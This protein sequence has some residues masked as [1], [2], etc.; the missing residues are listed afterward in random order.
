MLRRHEAIWSPAI[1]RHMN[2]ISYGHYGTPLI[3]FPSGL[4]NYF[5]WENFGMIDCVGHLIDAGKLKIYCTESND[6][7]TW[8]GDGDIRHRSWRYRCFE[9]YVLNNLVPTIRFDCKS[10]DI[11]IGLTGVSFGAYHAANFALKHPETFNY[12]LCMSGKYDL[13]SM[14]D[15][16]YCDDCYF[17]DPMA[18]LYNIWGEP[19]DRIRHNTH[20][21]MTVG[22][23]AHENNCIPQTH[24]LA[25][26]LHDKGIS[27]ECDTWGHDAEHHWHWWR[28]QL[29]HHLGRA[30]G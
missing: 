29:A 24:K 14:L 5:D 27:H 7:E 17:N 22:Q 23:G 13:G 15:G 8:I 26:L 10:P 30:L 4:G 20:I 18:Y 11:R 9:D 28:K 16:E 1:G 3:V 12:A 25:G 19:L 2:V 6:G 21:T